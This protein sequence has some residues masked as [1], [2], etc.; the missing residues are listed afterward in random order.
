MPKLKPEYK[1]YSTLPIK[2][3]HNIIN[4]EIGAYHKIDKKINP[5]PKHSGV[6]KGGLRGL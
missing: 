3:L 2:H 4:Q 5:T 6:A 1:Y